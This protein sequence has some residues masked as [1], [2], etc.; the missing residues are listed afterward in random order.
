MQQHSYK[1]QAEYVRAQLDRTEIAWFG[2]RRLRHHM[3][4]INQ[5]LRCMIDLKLPLMTDARIVSMGV[6]RGVELIAWEWKGYRNVVGVELSPKKEHRK[7]I[8]ADFSHLEN[9]F[10]DKSC[11]VIYACHSFEHAYDPWIT[12][13]EWKRIL[14]ANGVIWISL[15]TTLGLSD[16]PSEVH[17]VLIDQVTD[18]ENLFDPLRVVWVTTEGSLNGGIDMNVVLL[19]PNQRD[20]AAPRSV[21]RDLRRRLRKGVL[22]SHLVRRFSKMHHRIKGDRDYELEICLWIERL[23]V[24]SFKRSE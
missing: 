10:P 24:L 20:P 2:G 5:L 9:V 1:S 8:S 4:Y 18:I 6:R 19:D 7:I 14:K 12:A 17:P 11:D 23:K 16:D 13:T 15:P 22:L 3:H 21:R